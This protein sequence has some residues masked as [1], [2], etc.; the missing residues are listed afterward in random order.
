MLHVCYN[1]DMKIIRI[2]DVLH[3]QLKVEANREG[4]TLQW[5]VENKLMGSE[6]ISQNFSQVRAQAINEPT[7]T[8]DSQEYVKPDYPIRTQGPWVTP[9]MASKAK[10]L[11]DLMSSG[12]IKRGA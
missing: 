11:D 2:D 10:S 9:P 8:V 5:W 6:K 1:D 4:R 7:Y 12:L 3:K